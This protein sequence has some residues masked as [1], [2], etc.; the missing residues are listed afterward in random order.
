MAFT[1]I[2]QGYF[3]GSG[4]TMWYNGYN[5]HASWYIGKIN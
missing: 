1:Y 3:T 4:E 5:I 2:I